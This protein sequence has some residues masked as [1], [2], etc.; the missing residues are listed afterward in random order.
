MPH[1]DAVSALIEAMTVEE[2]AA[3]VVGRT[4][5]IVGG[6]ERLGVPEWTVSDGPVGARGRS[7]G[8][9][10]LLP[11][12]SAVAAT[13]DVA[14]IERLGVALAEECIDRKVDVLLGPTVNLHRSPRAGR[15]FECFSE[16]PELSAKV[17]VAY[18]NGVQSLGVGAC[19][20]H[21]VANEQ[22][23]ERHT[24]DV[25]VD[26]RALREVYLRP[27]EAA[28]READVKSVMAAYNFVNGQHACAQRDLLLG[29]LKE[30][31]GF[32]GL[33]VSDWGAVK[34][35]VSAATAGLDLEMPGPGRHWGNGKLLTAIDAG[36]VDLAVL[37]DKVER[38]LNFLAWRGRLNASTD[39][40]EVSIE[41]TEHRALVRDAASAG[42]VLVK[43]ESAVLPLDSSQRVALIGP[44]VAKTALMG[45]GSASLR[46]HRQGSLLEATASRPVH[47]THACG[48]DMTRNAP[49]VPVEWIEPGSIAVE[50]F[51][52]RGFAGEPFDVQSPE[53]I[54]NVWM[55][56]S[57]PDE[58]EEM[59]VR[60]RFTM[61]PTVSGPHRI[62][63]VGFARARLLVNGSLIADT[64]D[65]CFSAGLGMNATDALINL[66]AAVPYDVVVETQ[67]GPGGLPIALVD[68]RCGPAGPDS[69]TLLDEA[70]EAA[71]AA[72][73]A[74]VVV[75]SSSE[76]ER[77]G[78]DRESLSLPNNQ[79]ELVRRV[80]AANS[81]TVVVLNCGA[82]L[83]M[84]WFDDVS[85]VLLAWYPGQEGGE[86]IA[87]VLFGDAEPGGRMPTTW[88]RHES[89]TPS[90]LHYPGSGG[91]VAYGEGVFVGHRGF[92]RAGI[93][94]LIP[95][96]H[97]GSYTTFEWGNSVCHG[98]GPDLTLEVT[99][100]NTGDRPGTDVVQLYVAPPTSQVERPLKV[101]AGFAKV[102]LG[103]GETE[104]AK[105]ELTER[106]FAR[107]DSSGSG[108]VIDPGPYRLIVAA[109]ATD[110]RAELTV[111]LAGGD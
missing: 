26:E 67:P 47:I 22:E 69:A 95:F 8:P 14:L 52:G 31:W 83:S 102:H 7:M 105:I 41:H 81:N 109:S 111:E 18:I 65:D 77:E 48:V 50:F 5:W 103:P 110:V 4:T 71:S 63:G 39:H 13:F 30:E 12:P 74:V 92:E 44:G 40:E 6:C 104:T 91:T 16:D 2:K 75:G 108:W 56:D 43:N 33:V 34:E 94:P 49:S 79:D 23:H 84:P 100:T 10:L 97:G 45:G 68:A 55:G 90:Y 24:I 80:V 15:H 19:I 106:A 51:A 17:A 87:D 38:I 70:E 32:Q 88:A 46:P 89:D 96:G 107:W 64:V 62:V 76:W 57:W 93:E 29:I 3:M 20:K 86:A 61:T 72:D 98:V 85:S 82:P 1:A 54:F 101:L 21:F 37:D 28:V 42:M 73:V 66:D 25:A 35:G 60:L 58:V 11:G 27:F 99:V 59:S 9:A 53:S 36:E 78:A